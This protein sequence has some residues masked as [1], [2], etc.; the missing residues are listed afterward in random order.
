MLKLKP[1][2]KKQDIVLQHPY[3][4][5]MIIINNRG[6]KKK[7]LSRDR[8]ER[9]REAIKKFE[10]YQPEINIE[11]VDKYGRVLDPKSAFRELSQKFHGKY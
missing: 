9:E 4:K 11:Y 7:I 5:V 10:N 3:P 8:Y 1:F 2:P 6:K